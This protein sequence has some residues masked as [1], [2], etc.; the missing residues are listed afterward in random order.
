M[1][2]VG[3]MARG[4]TEL[5]GMS[6]LADP[7]DELFDA[8]AARPTAAG[9][10]VT[11]RDVVGLPAIMAPASVIAEDVGKLGMDLGVYERTGPRSRQRVS[12]RDGRRLARLL[13]LEPNPEQSSVEFWEAI[14]GFLKLWHRAYAYVERNRNGRVLGLW[15]MAPDRTKPCRD[16]DTGELLGYRTEVGDRREPVD[17]LPG[18]VLAFT[19]GA[20]ALDG[21]SPIMRH[22]EALGLIVAAQ[23]YAARY[24]TNDASAGGIIEIPADAPEGAGDKVEA[25][26]RGRHE[27]LSRKHRVGIL[28]GG[29]QW[30]DVGAPPKDAQFVESQRLGL[31]T[32]CRLMRCPPHKVAELERATFSNIEHQSIEYVVDSLGGPCARIVVELR[33]KLLSTN[34]DRFGEVGERYAAFNFDGLLRGDIETRYRAYAIGRQWGWLSADDVRAREDDSPLPNGQ[35]DHYL[36]PLNMIPAGQTPDRPAPASR[37][38][39]A[40]TEGEGDGQLELLGRLVRML[41]QV[42]EP[43]PI[44]RPDA[45]AD[46]EVVEARGYLPPGMSEREG[47]A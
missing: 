8:L 36:Q 9:V 37:G 44:D 35:G 47:D 33:R 18:D 3:R 38:A 12:D 16:R 22:R 42:P 45:I 41:E 19:A 10:R 14:A 23:E 40:A 46:A 15:P 1:S 17:L 30:K 31:L 24:F 4:A 25:R 43:W 5:R 7:S 20:F 6:G 11:D 2:I 21:K 26:W 27:G 29:A 39:A 32:G 34:P 28:E 13:S